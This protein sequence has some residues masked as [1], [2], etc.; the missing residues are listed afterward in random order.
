MGNC[1][2]LYAMTWATPGTG[3]LCGWDH[4]PLM[5]LPVWGPS[6]L[7]RVLWSAWR[8]GIHHPHHEG[9][10]FQ[11]TQPHISFL[12][13]VDGALSALRHSFHSG[14]RTRPGGEGTCGRSSHHRGLLSSL[15]HESTVCRVCRTA[16]PRRA[17][18]LQMLLLLDEIFYNHLN[19]EYKRL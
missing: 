13:G 9:Q 15:F 11:K 19:I 7:L 10:S 1:K 18:C 17:K 6:S 14:L 16:F 4:R 5:N 8:R 2:R 12:P 3:D